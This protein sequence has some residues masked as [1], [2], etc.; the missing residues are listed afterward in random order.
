M[1]ELSTTIKPSILETTVNVAQFIKTI[2]KDYTRLEIQHKIEVNKA[3]NQIFGS[4][5]SD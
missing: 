5:K 4:N 3:R 1:T 2:E